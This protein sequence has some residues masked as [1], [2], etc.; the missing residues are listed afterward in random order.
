M[1]YNGFLWG[2]VAMG[3]GLIGSGFAGAAVVTHYTFDD[4]I[5][6]SATSG[7]RSDHLISREAGGDIVTPTYV[8]GVIDGA[9]LIDNVP[10]EVFMFEVDVEPSLRYEPGDFDFG[11]SYT[12]ETYYKRVDGSY[13]DYYAKIVRQRGVPEGWRWS[14]GSGDIYPSIQIFCTTS[15]CVREG[16]GGEWV[17]GDDGTE[18]LS[19]WHHLAITNDPVTGLSM[20]QDGKLISSTAYHMS[21]KNANNVYF[22]GNQNIESGFYMDDFTIWDEVKYE[23]YM[24]YRYG[25]IPEPASAAALYACLI[26]LATI[27]TRRVGVRWR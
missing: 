14:I 5:K 9:V 23:G 17:R 24:R 20:W 22:G 10:G 8:R 13:S 6:D 15:T 18:L 3:L 19:G 4:N 7:I 2:L 27:L 12:M 21:D 16:G 25:L 26:F 11:V 1:R